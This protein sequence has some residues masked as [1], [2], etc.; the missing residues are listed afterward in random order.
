MQAHR[1][2]SRIIFYT[3]DHE[4]LIEL[5]KLYNG[6]DVENTENRM[7][8][9]FSLGKAFWDTKDFDKSFKYYHEANNICRKNVSFFLDKEKMFFKEIK[10]SFTKKIFNKYHNAGC[11]DLNPI[12]IIGMPRSGTT[13]IEQIIS[14]N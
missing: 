1:I 4:H 14:K 6:I 13:L 2:L 10:N 5:K 9:A 12:F 7:L 3:D 8:L 11:L